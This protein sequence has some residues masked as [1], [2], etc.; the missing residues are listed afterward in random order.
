MKFFKLAK[1]SNPSFGKGSSMRPNRTSAKKG[2]E[3]I[4][5][6]AIIFQSEEFYS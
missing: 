5:E 4:D 2:W 3:G 1:D 6:T